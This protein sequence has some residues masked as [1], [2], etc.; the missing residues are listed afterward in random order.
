[1]PK[2]YSRDFG[3][4][5]YQSGDPFVF[6]GGLPGFPNETAFLPVEVPEQIPLLYLQ[7]LATP[8]LCFVSL[9]A[10]CIVSDYDLSPNSDDY[11]RIGLSPDVRPGPQMLCLALVCFTEDGS[12]AANLRAPIIINL[13]N[14]TGIQTIQS[15]DRYPIRFPLRPEK[16]APC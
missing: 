5:D 4:I 2:V 13:Q 12:A 6:P 10:R 14:R 9:P 7:S 3:A 8:D 15:D 16:E 11:A 1:M